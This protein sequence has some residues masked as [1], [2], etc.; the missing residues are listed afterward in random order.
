MVD[1]QYIGT[2]AS[3]SELYPKI[4]AFYENE[5]KHHRIHVSDNLFLSALELKA[6]ADA[7]GTSLQ[8]SSNT[9]VIIA[10]RAETE[11]KYT[12]LLYHLRDSKLRILVCFVRGQGQSSTVLYDSNKCHIERFLHYRVDLENMLSYLDVGPNYKMLGFSLGGLIS[13]EFCFNTKFPY[14]P[15]SLALICPF[16]GIPN[17]LAPKVVY[18]ILKIMCNI[19]SFALSYTP[20]GKEYVRIPFEENI[21][22]HSPLR[23]DIY[24]DYYIKHP[25]LALAGPTYKFVKCCMQAQ[26]RLD[27]I[28]CKFD[29]PM[30]CLSAGADMVVSTP[31]AREFCQRHAHDTI[32]PQFEL[33][34]HA[35]HDILNESDNYRNDA[36]LKALN[37][38]FN[39]TTDYKS[40]VKAPE[41]N[42]EPQSALEPQDKP[43]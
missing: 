12:E 38:L 18:P 14:K 11:H 26:Q 37:F 41:E 27:K 16:L 2:E 22:S 23:Y 32:A 7:P 13:L 39:G 15:Q 1:L 6:P 42:T 33:I 29:F 20:H 43:E 17:L 36:M 40:L 24:H 10:G 31:A 25:Q 3:L 4:D 34:P 28:K 21:H 30:L 5:L 35:Y 19:R 9:L 8:D